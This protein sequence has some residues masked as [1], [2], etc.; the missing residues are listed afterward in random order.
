MSQMTQYLR[1]DTPNNDPRSQVFL[2]Y[3][4]G[5]GKIKYMSPLG[6]EVKSMNAWETQT[7]TLR[8]TGDLLKEQMPD[9]TPEKHLDKVGSGPLPAQANM[10]CWQEDN[11]H[12]NGQLCLINGCCRVYHPGGRQ[13]KGKWENNRTV[14][15]FKVFKENC[16][17]CYQVFLEHF[18]KMLKTTASPTTGPSTMQPTAPE[19]SYIAWIATGD[20]AGL[21]I[22]IVLACVHDKKRRRCSQEARQGTSPTQ[23]LSLRLLCLLH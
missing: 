13:M 1:G 5:T 4:C 20:L 6:E 9:V 17:L 2:S 16:Q 23:G 18:E 10:T 12:I 7:D 21:V 22:I 8:D 14:T 3:D 15:F 11:G 19:S